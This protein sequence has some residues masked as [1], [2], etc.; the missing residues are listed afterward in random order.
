MI[1]GIWL[2]SNSNK[3]IKNIYFISDSNPTALGE[4]FKK[5]NFN[6][7]QESKLVS[8]PKW[9]GFILKIFSPFLPFKASVLFNDS[10]VCS[11]KKIESLGFNPKID[12]RKGLINTVEWMQSENIG[13]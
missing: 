3:A 2:L 4:I 13:V 12:Y 8:L 10:L 6:I 11:S 1:N 9:L 5:I 7:G